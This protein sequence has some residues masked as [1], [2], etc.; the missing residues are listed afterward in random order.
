[1]PV[2]TVKKWGNSPAVRIPVS[3]MQD[4]AVNVDDEFEISLDNGRIILAPVRAKKYSLAELLDG[5]TDENI[6][7]RVDFGA[8]VGK[9]LL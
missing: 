7:D 2:V 5:V 4:A 8:A 3:V 9:E 6:H 1:M